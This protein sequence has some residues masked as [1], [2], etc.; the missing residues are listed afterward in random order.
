[1]LA[2]LSPVRGL[3]TRGRPW[4]VVGTAKQWWH[5]HH[6][7]CRGPVRIKVV[8]AHELAQVDTACAV[9]HLGWPGLC[10]ATEKHRQWTRDCTGAASAYARV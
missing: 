8:E 5:G 1:V 2:L 3:A 6:R 10:E 9:A 7:A 4:R